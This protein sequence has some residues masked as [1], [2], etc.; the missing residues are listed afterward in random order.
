MK[1]FI[2]FYQSIEQCDKPHLKYLLSIQKDDYRSVFGRNVK[3]ICEEAGAVNISEVNLENIKYVALPP[4]DQ[5]RIPM[6][7]DLL[8]ARAGRLYIDLSRRDIS[9]LIYEVTTS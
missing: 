4:E 6:L 3:N 9:R 7:R 2:K 5:W 1:R 8:E